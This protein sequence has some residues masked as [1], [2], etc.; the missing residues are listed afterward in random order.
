M[1]DTIGERLEE[2]AQQPHKLSGDAGSVEMPKLPDLIAADKYA[3][4]KEA[5]AEALAASGSFW[6]RY[7]KIE[8]ASPPG[9]GGG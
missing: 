9:V 5:A 7:A 8:R 6:K 4:G 3:T 2:L 1:A